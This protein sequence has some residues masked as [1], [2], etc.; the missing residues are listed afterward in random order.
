MRHIRKMKKNEET[1]LSLNDEMVDLICIGKQEYLLFTNDSFYE[2]NYEELIR[3][4][5]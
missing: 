5:R 3:K 2:I 1:T 4:Y